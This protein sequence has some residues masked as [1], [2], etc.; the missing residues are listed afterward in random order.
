[1][2][3]FTLSLDDFIITFFTAG[4]GSSTLPLLVYGMVK[5]HITPEINA[6]STIWVASVLVLLLGSQALQSLQSRTARAS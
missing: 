6:L 5:T 4:P 3:A 2:L 1:M